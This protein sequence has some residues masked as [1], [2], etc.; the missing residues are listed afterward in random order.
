MPELD[1]AGADSCSRRADSCP[2]DAAGRTGRLEP[3]GKHRRLKAARSTRGSSPQRLARVVHGRATEEGAPMKTPRLLLVILG[4]VMLAA[5][6]YAGKFAPASHGA[7][8]SGP[9]ASDFTYHR[10]MQVLRGT[11]GAGAHQQLMNATGAQRMTVNSAGVRQF[12][13]R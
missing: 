10:T 2:R 5:P 9:G 8:R 4:L 1:V 11:Y 6:A 3:I 7:R 13:S 12:W